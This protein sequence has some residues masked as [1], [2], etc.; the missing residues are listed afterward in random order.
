MPLSSEKKLKLVKNDIKVM[1]ETIEDPSAQLAALHTYKE[2]KNNDLEFLE[3]MLQD[4]S[5][6]KY[7]L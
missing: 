4:I 1:I 2:N 7:S 3:I 5:D 6:G